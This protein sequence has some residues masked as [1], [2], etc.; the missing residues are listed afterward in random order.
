[1]TEEIKARLRKYNSNI[2]ISGRGVVAFG[3]WTAIKV[4]IRMVFG[5]EEIRAGLDVPEAQ[6]DFYMQVIYVTMGFLC[7]LF[8]AIHGYV[9]FCAI[10]YGRGNRKNKMFLIG[11]LLIAGLSLFFIITDLM[12][13]EIT[14]NTV[15]EL[16]ADCTLFFV[17]F[18]MLY[19]MYMARLTVKKAQG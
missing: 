18:D 12:E 3:L 16:L 5:A 19:S 11:A 10:R 9:G 13:K 4:I 17:M 7:V 8:M 2:E 6:V 15:A 14:F 1:M